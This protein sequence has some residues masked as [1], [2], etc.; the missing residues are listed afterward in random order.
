MIFTDKKQK[1]FVLYADFEAPL[2]KMSIRER[3]ILFTMIYSYVNR[4]CID[5]FLKRTPLVDVTFE[6]IRAQLDRDR[7]KYERICARNAENGKLGGR[8]SKDEETQKTQWVSGKP[9]KSYNDNNN[10]N[11]NKNKNNSDSDIDNELG[12]YSSF[13]SAE[14]F[15]AAL[16]RS[17]AEGEEKK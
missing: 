15:A 3:G 4:G 8:K 9:K 12:P 17:Y 2:L 1:S 7:E 13:D 16:A 10:D 6:I 11:K 14:F 5:T